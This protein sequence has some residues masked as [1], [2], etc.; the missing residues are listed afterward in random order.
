MTARAPVQPAMQ[1]PATQP[2]AM[3]PMTPTMPEPPNGGAFSSHPPAP[4]AFAPPPA[5][6][7][8]RPR[9]RGTRPVTPLILAGVGIVMC[10]VL[11]V[12]GGRVI[13]RPTRSASAA[14]SELR[15]NAISVAVAAPGPSFELPANPA[16]APPPVAA[17][18][19]TASSLP[20]VAA[21]AARSAPSAAP[22]SVAR[23]A[24][25]PNPY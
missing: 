6:T 13:R 11:A 16:P 5:D 21:S 12:V 25:P 23:R 10:G 19:A 24:L 20:A 2:P 22:S 7:W 1:P 8:R 14:P 18:T 15:A 17:V 9:P 4:L 3:Q